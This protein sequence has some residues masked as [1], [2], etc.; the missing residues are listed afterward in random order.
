LANERN[1]ESYIAFQSR[2]L[3]KRV[4]SGVFYF[5]GK[6]SKLTVDVPNL[7]VHVFA[8]FRISDQTSLSFA[9]ATVA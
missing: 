2:T 8:K 3:F 4:K 6:A 1:G 5:F 7:S 9:A